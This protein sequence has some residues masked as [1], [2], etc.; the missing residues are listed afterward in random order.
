MKNLSALLQ[1]TSLTGTFVNEGWAVHS[2][3]GAVVMIIV[4]ISEED[5]KFVNIALVSYRIERPVSI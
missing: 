1:N 4:W 3:L 5:W 2:A